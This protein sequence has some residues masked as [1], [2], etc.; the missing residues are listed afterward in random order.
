MDFCNECGNTTEP[1]WVFCR[2]CGNSLESSEIESVAAQPIATSNSPKVELIS[3]GWDV[4]DVEVAADE[5]SSTLPTDPLQTNEIVMP[6][7]PD[8]V[9]ISV[10]EVTVVARPEEAAPPEAAESDSAP[11]ASSDRWDHLRPHGQI[12]GVSDPS[13]VPAKASQIAV[14]TTAFGALVS[15]V[16][17]LFLNIQLDDYAA[18]EISEGA[19][20]DVRAVAE[21]SLLVLAGLAIVAGGMALGA[22]AARP[23]VLIEERRAGGLGQGDLYL[24]LG[25][26]VHRYE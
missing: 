12:P 1:E 26:I 13:K 24:P 4:V 11:D 3:R 25:K 2:S 21:A 18:G 7:D 23:D 10:D 15:A 22:L 14:L 16:L 17:Y 20:R 8:A 5:S 9:E 6:L 19:V